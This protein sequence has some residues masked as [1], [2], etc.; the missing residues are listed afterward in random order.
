MTPIVVSDTCACE[1][2]DWERRP[3]IDGDL[4]VCRSCGYIGL[5]AEQPGTVSLHRV[6]LTLCSLCL[7]GAGGECHTPGCDLWMH[8]APDTRVYVDHD[9]ALAEEPTP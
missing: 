2:N 1:R 6:T 8:A 7:S 4:I 9:P 3:G 5:I